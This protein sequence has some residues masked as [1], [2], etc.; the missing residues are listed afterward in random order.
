MFCF[1]FGFKSVLF[2]EQEKLWYIYSSHPAYYSK[3]LSNAKITIKL[4]VRKLRTLN[5]QA[6]LLKKEGLLKNKIEFRLFI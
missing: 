3:Y 2:V 6:I 4:Y 1:N 5:I